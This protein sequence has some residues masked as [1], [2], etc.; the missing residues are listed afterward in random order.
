MPWC[1]LEKIRFGM[2]D[3]GLKTADFDYELPPELIAQHP[4]KERD[5]S[6]LLVLHRASGKIEHRSFSD[7]PEYLA[8]AD[9]LVLNDTRVFPARLTGT[10]SGG[11]AFEALLV[12]RLEGPRAAGSSA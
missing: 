8:P 9:V 12:R 11:A 4:A 1:K 2:P 6:R 7:L 3:S 5:A 10:L